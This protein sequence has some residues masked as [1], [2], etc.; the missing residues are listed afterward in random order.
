MAVLAVLVILAVLGM[1]PVSAVLAVLAVLRYWLRLVVSVDV[2]VGI[3][4]ISTVLYALWMWCS[5]WFNV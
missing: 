4:I 1:L 2:V 3:G 5:N